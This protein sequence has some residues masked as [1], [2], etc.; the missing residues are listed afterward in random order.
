MAVL[1][2]GAAWAQ[3]PSTP[4]PKLFQ[5]GDFI[6][7]KK[8]GAFVPYESGS[9]NT[10]EEDRVQWTK[11]RDGYIARARTVSAPDREMRQR[12]RA[13]RAMD[14]REFHAHYAGDQEPG[15]PGVYKGGGLYVGHVAIIE[16]DDGTPWVVEA[17]KGKGV[18]RL[19]YADWLAGRPKEAVWLGRLKGID[20]QRRASLVGEALKHVGK[21]YDFWN[22][23]L[24]EDS[25]FYCSKLCW[26]AIF[27][28]LGFAVDGRSNP[29]RA[30]WF[31]PKQM[32]NL[33]SS[34]DRL[35][36]PPGGYSL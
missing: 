20:A 25:G 10:P 15:Q 36:E 35:Y 32:L 23:N 27:R 3:A 34:I 28:A 1:G 30:L 31:S 18:V 17:M 9:D 6:W 14:Y 29:Q 7:P 8:P 4:N 16:I 12:L 19:T 5:S 22:F 24:D 2:S 21:P 11:E 26:L 13:L 33:R